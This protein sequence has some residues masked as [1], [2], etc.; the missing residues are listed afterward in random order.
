MSNLA[1]S[2]VPIYSFSNSALNM[3]QINSNIRVDF[4]GISA[5]FKSVNIV[6]CGE[7]LL[8]PD[9]DDDPVTPGYIRHVK[10]PR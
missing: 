3:Y 1:M 7:E 8:F 9:V 5:C 6:L 10:I 4:S 2:H